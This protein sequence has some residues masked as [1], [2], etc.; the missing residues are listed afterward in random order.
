M[1]YI[2][3]SALF[4]VTGMY[5]FANEYPFFTIPQAL[6][7][8]ANVVKRAEEIR[9]EL[10]NTRQAKYYRKVVYTVL[11]EKGDDY[12]EAVQP[13]DKILWEEPSIQG[14]LYDAM[15]SKLKTTKK[16]DIRDYSNVDEGTLAANDRVRTH[17]FYH[18]VYPYTVEYIIEQD[19]NAT[20]FFPGWIPCPASL[21]SVES[22]VMTVVVPSGET[23]RYKAVNGA[24]EPQV[25]TDGT[26]KIYEW[27]LKQF[28][29]FRG[30]YAAPVV[31]EI[32]PAV[33][34]GP[35]RFYIE[36][37]EG[38]MNTWKEYGNFV[39]SLKKDKVELPP[40]VKQKVHELTDGLTNVRT[41]TEVLYQY[42]QQ[43]TRYISIQL[44]IGGWQ[45]FPASFVADKKYGDCKA[46]TNYM[47]ALLKE[48]GIPSGYTVIKTRNKYFYPD[49]PSSQFDHVIL[50]VPQPKDSIWL[51]CTSQTLPAGYL[52]SFTHDRYAVFVNEEGG[53][54]V[55]TPT[56][57]KDQN[58]QVRT[59]KA[60]VNIENSSLKISSSTVYKAMQQDQLHSLLKSLT[61]EKLLEHLKQE[62]DLPHYDVLSFDYQQFP[63]TLPELKEV[64]QLVADNYVQVS[65]RRLF[66]SPNILSRS[67]RKPA[68]DTA[69]KFPVVLDYSYTDIDSVEIQIPAGYLAESVP[70]DQSVVS[71][72]GTYT[73]VTKVLPGKILYYRKHIQHAGTF[74]PADYQAMVVFFD[75][76]YK[77]D[78]SKVVL[79]KQEE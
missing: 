48:A 16:S 76:L 22:S 41:K 29:A 45:P 15:G 3:L 11:N 53:H 21:L 14:T 34:M 6:L 58:L 72:F 66:I 71:K 55:R 50:C 7:K 69:R 8:H 63:G 51:E 37:Y 27:S 54:L 74:S 65:N 31:T 42:M 24:G 79:V 57:G 26:K 75:Q 46:L 28:P 10:K 77:A 38:E 47:H 5:S 12:A 23:F 64:L 60:E 33:L 44:G 18:K 49:F 35:A 78:R 62:L 61:K 39:H 52:S 59:I 17:N 70:K 1:K 19:Y 4:L 73:T 9:F 32:T 67:T 43:H 13:Y 56:Y 68:S 36:G 2:V 30:E 20:M 25:R 40:A